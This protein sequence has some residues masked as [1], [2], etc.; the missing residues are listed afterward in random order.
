MLRARLHAESPYFLDELKTTKP[1]EYPYPARL[2]NAQARIGLS[3]LELLPENLAW[4]RHVAALYE[5]A[6]GAYAGIVDRDGSNHAFVRYVFLAAD[7]TAWQTRLE[8]FVDM[9]VWFTSIAH[10][11]ERGLET[12]GYREGSCV[13][14][15]HAARRCVNLPTYP[16]LKDPAAVVERVR[17]MHE[18]APLVSAP[19]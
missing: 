16:R 3:Q 2:G 7:R 18:H 5:D 4:R 10:G 8:D 1:T 19:V 12:I 15:E 14:A 9:G 13:V 11:R 17:A 6:L